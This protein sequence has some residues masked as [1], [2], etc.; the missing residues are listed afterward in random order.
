[1]SFASPVESPVGANQQVTIVIPTHNRAAFLGRLLQYYWSVRTASPI[2]VADSSTCS[3]GAEVGAQVAS[4]EK[5][6]NIAHEHFPDGILAKVRDALSLVRTSYAVLA[7]DDDFFVPRSLEQGVQYLESHPDYSIVHGE[8]AKFAV[9]PGASERG[10]IVKVRRYRQR[11]IELSTGSERLADHLGNYTT[12]WYSLG[13][14]HQLLENFTTL[15]ASDL[16]KAEFGELLPSCLSLV[17]G[18]SK[19]LT[20]LYMLR[21]AHSG[22]GSSSNPDTLEWLADVSWPDQYERFRD[23]LAEALIDQDGVTLDEARSG[24]KSA[25][26]TYLAQ[27]LASQRQILGSR[28]ASVRLPRRVLRRVPGLRRGW[29]ATRRALVLRRAGH[30]SG[31]KASEL[32]LSSLLS[33]TSPY[34]D[35]FLPMY[36]ATLLSSEAARSKAAFPAPVAGR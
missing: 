4:Y 8:A 23:C 15:V 30:A 35:D 13:R 24:A 32:S 27:R 14:T 29:R 31:A 11:S 34:S 5:R 16:G 1:M 10:R 7:A 22:S 9:E 18:K 20:G 19:K 21:Q 28:A 26:W 3:Q 2:L 36:R 25:F 33:G 6:L 12:T 17:Q